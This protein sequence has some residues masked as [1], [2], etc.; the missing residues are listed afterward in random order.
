MAA[1]RNES[2]T[3]AIARFREAVDHPLVRARERLGRLYDYLPFAGVV[4][5]VV[6]LAILLEGDDKIV[7]LKVFAVIYFSLLP[8]ILYLQFTARKTPTVWREYVLTLF[9]LHAD[10]YSNLP[11]PPQTSRYHAPW[12][13]AR[14]VLAGSVDGAQ[15][16][17]REQ[18]NVYRRRFEEQYGPLSLHED[19]RDWRNQAVQLQRAHKLQ[20]L[21]ATLLITLA[22]SSSSSPRRSRSLRHTRL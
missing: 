20:V 21:I 2:S 1:A 15:H 5:I 3:D 6:V 8:A 7:A 13:Q 17:L 10:D 9:R 11:E 14:C 4:L 19:R 22:G 18:Q 16:A 12:K